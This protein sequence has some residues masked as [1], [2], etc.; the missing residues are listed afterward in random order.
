MKTAQHLFS[1]IFILLLFGCDTDDLAYENLK[2][3]EIGEY[4]LQAP[5]N[6]KLLKGQGYDS[7]VGKIEGSGITLSFDHGPYTSPEQNVS[8]VDYIIFNATI[9][10]FA[11]QI[12]KAKDPQRNNTTLHIHYYDENT[13]ENNPPPLKIW[14]SHLNS[15]QQD[16]VINIFNSV[17]VER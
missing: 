14:T 10:G 17:S 12:L 1:L 2:T 9:D 6:F 3:I 16:L 8:E 7:N 5:E 4:R 11:R 15:T 13:G